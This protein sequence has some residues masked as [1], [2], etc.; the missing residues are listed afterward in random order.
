M[1]FTVEFFTKYKPRALYLQ[2]YKKL[3]TTEIRAL[4]IKRLDGS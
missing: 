2:A 3:K 1:E 4:A